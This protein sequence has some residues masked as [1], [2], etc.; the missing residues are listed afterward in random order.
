MKAGTTPYELISGHGYNSTLCPF[1][2]PV[3]VFVGDSVKQKGDSKWHRGIFSH[4]V[5]EQ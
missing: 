5:H 4:E 1:G 3:M 2:C